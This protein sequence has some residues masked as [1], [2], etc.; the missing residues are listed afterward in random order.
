MYLFEQEV[1]IIELTLTRKDV[2]VKT[3]GGRTDGETMIFKTAYTFP[4]E[5]TKRLKTNLGECTLS[6]GFKIKISCR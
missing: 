3:F 2:E 6:T 1:T 5:R 4:I